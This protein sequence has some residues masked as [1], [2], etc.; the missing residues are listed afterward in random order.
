MGCDPLPAWDWDWVWDWV[1]PGSPKRDARVTL[2]WRVGHAWVEWGKC[3]C[4]QQKMKNEG[5]G[6]GVGFADLDRSAPG[7]AA[8]LTMTICGA[9]D[10]YAALLY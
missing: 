7:C 4:L 6:H 3:L 8:S 10:C 9:G 2:G 1:T 5:V